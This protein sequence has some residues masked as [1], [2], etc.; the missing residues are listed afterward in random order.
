MPP[1]CS[2]LSSAFG[3]GNGFAIGLILLNPLFT[4]MLAFGDAKY[5]GV[6]KKAA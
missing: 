4:L 6:P 2:C 5:Q 3:K 1:D